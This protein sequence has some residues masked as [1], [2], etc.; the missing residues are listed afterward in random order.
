MSRNSIRVLHVLPV[1]GSAG[2]EQLAANLM[3]P[4]ART[5]QVA[6]LG[7]YGTVAGGI[8]TR[9]NESGIR[10]WTLDKTPGFDPRMIA[11]VHRVLREFAPDVVH[12]HLHVVPYV[13]APAMALRI[14]VWV[15]TVHNLAE[16]E[17]TGLGRVA[18]RIAFRGGAMPV[19]VSRVVAESV[20]AVYSLKSVTTIPNGIPLANFGSRA[21][22]RVRLR[23]ELSV[24]D[25]ATLFISTSRL[26]EQ[27]DPFLLLRAFAAVQDG[28]S[29]LA[30]VGDGPLR[31]ATQSQ[32]AELGL[33]SRV[34]VLGFRSDVEDC[35]AAA[36]V[37]V[38]SSRWEG[39]PL[40]V[41]E[42][43]A[44]G[45]PIVATRVGG[46]PE[47]VDSGKQGLLVEPEVPA[48][49]RAMRRL[50]ERRDLRLSL[51]DA[52]K[53]RAHNEFGIERMVRAYDEFY[54]KLLASSP[55]RNG[56]A[57]HAQARAATPGEE[58]L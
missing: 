20:R 58:P 13:Y 18:T 5:H 4:L 44:S 49:A 1:L 50:L 33:S 39:N 57:D 26:A 27:K 19:A 31:D 6:A 36:D 42:A 56:A 55:R 15:H 7:L 53:Q 14:P 22:A 30:L 43:M 47:L 32:I 2:A 35:L 8:H 3:V 10:F 54:N 25:N 16:R 23:R 24:P 48:L 21:A 29:R 17:S 37:F 40:G 46:L 41:M 11:R 12:T 45:L 51:A 34:S 9:L 38:L 28:R 52:A